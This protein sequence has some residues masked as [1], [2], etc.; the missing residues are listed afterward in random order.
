M[1][2]IIEPIGPPDEDEPQAP[3]WKRLAWFA[4]IALAASSVTVLTAYALKAF[5]PSH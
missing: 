1:P 3:L 2:A 5:I 4:G